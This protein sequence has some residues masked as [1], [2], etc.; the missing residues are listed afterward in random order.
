MELALGPALF[1]S[2]WMDE[3]YAGSKVPD[4]RVFAGYFIE[5][6]FCGGPPRL[7]P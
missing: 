1:V 4:R 3:V 6:F 7:I 2:A 5:K